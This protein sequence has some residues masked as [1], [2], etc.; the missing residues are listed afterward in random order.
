MRSPA[1]KGTLLA[2]AVVRVPLLL[3]LVFLVRYPLL[4]A[5]ERRWDIAGITEFAI[6]RLST[7]LARALCLMA[8][9][10]PL[11]ALTHAT[12]RLAVAKRN[13]IV[14]GVGATFL[15]AV[16]TLTGT[17]R[18]HALFALLALVGSFTQRAGGERAGLVSSAASAF[19]TLGAGVVE[20]LSLRPYLGWLAQSLGRAELAAR[21]AVTRPWGVA[22]AALSVASMAVCSLHGLKLIPLERFLRSSSGVKV[23]ATADFNYMALDAAGRLFVTG[24]GLE[25]IR[26]YDRPG[27]DDAFHEAKVVTGGA[28]SMD[29]DARSGELYVANE[30]ALKLVVFDPETLTA[31]REVPTPNLSPGDATIAVDS[32]AGT[33]LVGSEA[34]EQTGI[35][36]LVLDRTTGAV[37]ERRTEQ[38][39]YL[40]PH[41]TLPYVYVSFFRRRRG[42]V[43]YDMAERRVRREA[44]CDSRVD[45]LAFWVA[46]NELLVASPVEARVLRF[47]ALT[48]ASKGAFEVNFGVRAI[49]VDERRQLLLSSSLILGTLRV[50]SLTDGAPRATYYLGR[51]LRQIVVREDAARAYVSSNGAL[52]SVD[53]AQ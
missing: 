18:R 15:V 24:H 20:A 52:Y 33:I 31:K 51:W 23:L 49:A 25:R 53:Y 6:D 48:L 32:R 44:P 50:F 4:D 9:A 13:L 8:I 27:I 41:P 45:G 26:R 5:I 47:D 34:D 17:P 14:L 1:L 21:L 10:L 7:P 39:A 16:F 19:F 28:Q 43:L 11:V 46:R 2:W 12:R 30:G 36:L 37:V 3:G 22:I 42:I 40:Q 38:P 35:P 29:R